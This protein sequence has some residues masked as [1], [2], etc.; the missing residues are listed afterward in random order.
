VLG[1]SDGVADR[2]VLGT[3]GDGD[4]LIENGQTHDQQMARKG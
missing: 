2:L 1:Q 3:A 4:R